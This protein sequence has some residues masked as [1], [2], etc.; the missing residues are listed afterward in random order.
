MCV[1]LSVCMCARGREKC[2]ADTQ[3]LGGPRCKSPGLLL[4]RPRALHITQREREIKPASMSSI[5]AHRASGRAE[6]YPQL[7]TPVSSEQKGGK[8][9]GGAGLAAMI[10]YES[11]RYQHRN[12]AGSL[13]S[14]P[15]KKTA[16]ARQ[17]Q[18]QR[19]GKNDNELMHIFHHQIT[20]IT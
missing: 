4:Q 16:H 9:A 3:G 11:T 5:S 14:P 15:P 17:F 10:I 8:V 19:S 7:S 12:M 1:C 6:D 20:Q 13:K 18:D 2:V